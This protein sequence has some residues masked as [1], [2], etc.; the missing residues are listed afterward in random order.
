MGLVLS[1]DDVHAA[2]IL[3]W[4][5]GVKA[6]WWKGNGVEGET[7]ARQPLMGEQVSCRGSVRTGVPFVQGR[8]MITWCA[9]GYKKSWC[10][11]DLA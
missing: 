2:P 10:S 4:R 7:S 5:V 8:Q 1:T 11:V 6:E 9:K 3:S